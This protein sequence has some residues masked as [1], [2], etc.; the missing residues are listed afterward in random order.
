MCPGCQGHGQHLL[1][2]P[3]HPLLHGFLH[4]VSV[5]V[6][7]SS[8]P[9]VSSNVC[10]SEFISRQCYSSCK[11]GN[12]NRALSIWFLLLWLAGDSCNLIGSF[13]AD[14]LP[15]QVIRASVVL[16]FLL[17]PSLVLLSFNIILELACQNI[18]NYVVFSAI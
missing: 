6:A 17:T 13:L 12:M 15:L 14:Q 10:N 1:R 18:I 16:F 7:V 2:P 3:L 5:C 8:T 4:P 9:F 11:T